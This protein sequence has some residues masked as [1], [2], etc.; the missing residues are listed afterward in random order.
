MRKRA[1]A[2]ILN[3]ACLAT[4]ALLGVLLAYRG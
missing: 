2:V 1:I 4:F 3:F